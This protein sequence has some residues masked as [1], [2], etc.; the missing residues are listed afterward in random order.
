MFVIRRSQKGD[1]D[2][3]KAFINQVELDE[4]AVKQHF[5]HFFL[6]ELYEEEYKRKDLVGIAGMEVYHSYGLFRSFILKKGD[7]NGKI[8]I[9]LIKIL[10]SYAKSLRLLEVYLLSNNCVYLFEQLGFEV[11]SYADLPQQL[12]HIKWGMEK[13]AV[14]MIYKCSKRE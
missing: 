1:L 8:G 11:I 9:Q 13:Q 6:V 10:L 14:P 12:D 3:V 7:W 2:R 4:S 5:E